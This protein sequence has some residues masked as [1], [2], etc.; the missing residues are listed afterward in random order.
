MDIVV[1]VLLVSLVVTM[2]TGISI[3][4]SLGLASLFAILVSDADFPIMI[5][6][7]RMFSGANRFAFLAIIYFILAGTIMQ[8]GGISNRLISFSNSLV[9][10]V[11]GGLS[12]VTLFTCTLFGAITGSSIATTAAIGRIMYP[13]MVEAGY[14]KGYSAAL[15]AVGGT[16]GIIIPPSIVFILYGTVTNTSISGLLLAGVIPGIIGGIAL[17]VTAY[18]YAKIYKFPKADD[19]SLREVFDKGKSAVL[20]MLMPVIILGGIYGG[21]FTPTESA[22]VAVAYGLILS[23]LVYRAISLK[24]F[25]EILIESAKVTSNIMILV[26]AATLF[27]WLLTANN[28]PQILS[29]FLFS[30]IDSPVIFLIGVNIILLFLGMFMEIGAVLLILGPL[31]APVAIGYGIDPVHFGLIMVFNLSLGQATPPFGT[32]LF[33]TCGISKQ[34]VVSVGKA[35]IPFILVLFAVVLLVTYVPI[36]ST[37][38][39]GM[40]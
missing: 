18:I 34:S 8:Y 19:F 28:V 26:M 33:V 22:A 24:V 29:D 17:L 1:I 3:A 27:G 31:F 5:M 4:W 23:V 35:I 20:A 6:S 15:P 21:I 9:G 38:L 36:I 37:W 32:C 30:I 11:S 25:K 13:E 39:P 10:H 40:M 2:S 12:L 7:M 16:L 14:P